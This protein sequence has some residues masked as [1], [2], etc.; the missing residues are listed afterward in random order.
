MMG[1]LMTIRGVGRG[2]FA[3]GGTAGGGALG[4]WIGI[5]TGP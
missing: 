1:V 3:V 4:I 2:P 5:G